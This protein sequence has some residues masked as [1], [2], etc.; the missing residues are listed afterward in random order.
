MNR[1]VD[2]FAIVVTEYKNAD[3]NATRVE[4]FYAAVVKDIQQKRRSCTP[5]QRWVWLRLACVASEVES[6]LYV[7]SLIKHIED[8]LRRNSIIT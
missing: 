1:I 3:L 2:Q 8:C 6:S 4:E 5:Q 7:V